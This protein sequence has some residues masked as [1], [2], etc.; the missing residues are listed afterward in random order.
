MKNPGFALKFIL[1]ML[2][3]IL[4]WNYFDF[5]QF[6]MIVFLPTLILCLPIRRNAVYAMLLAFGTGFAVDFFSSG[7][8]GLTSAA[9]VPVALIRRG[10]ITLVCGE[11][12][13]ARG[14]NI[15]IR[16]QGLPKMALAIMIVTALFLF[17][18][19]WADGAG[20]RPFWF[21][22][23]KFGASL[24]AGTLVSLLACNVLDSETR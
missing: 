9:L 11:E 20:T 6:L 22:A 15:T 12:V 3:Q 23:V 4:L 7:M 17:I 24:L 21:N 18:Y 5:T 13:F 19:I 1:L 14:E 2:T 10:V 16:R 8:L